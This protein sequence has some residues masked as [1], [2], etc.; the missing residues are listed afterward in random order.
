[1]AC[2]TC[3]TGAKAAAADGTTAPPVMGVH[4]AT[5]TWA[6]RPVEPPPP[7]VPVAPPAAADELPLFWII[8][9][10]LVVG[11]WVGRNR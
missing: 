3:A 5:T 10:A 6:E 1:M 7:P 11:W 4:T 2:M 9:V 8:L